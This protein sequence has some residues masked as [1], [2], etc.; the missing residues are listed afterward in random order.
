[1]KKYNNRAIILASGAGARSGLKIPK[2][3]A[4]INGRTVLERGI[5]AFEN[6]DGIDEI[7]LV[8][9]PQ[10][11]EKCKKIVSKNK[12]KKVIKIIPGGKTRQQSAYAGIS[13]VENPRA[14]ILIHDA[15]RPFVTA[16][17]IT[18]CINAL[19][20]YKAAGTAVPSADTIIKINKNNTVESV[21]ERGSLMRC[22]TPQA[23]KLEIIKKAHE[24]ALK[25][26]LA[27][28]TD[29]CGLVLRFKLAPVY[30]VPGDDSNIKITYPADILT[31]Q[32]ICRARDKQ[33]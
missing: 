17:I 29:D 16:R 24:L 8:S 27:S 30:V 23:F 14:N 22:Q 3:F 33:K 21:L 6:H 19:K 20:K 18:D 15:A 13:E 9:A 25:N 5:D 4:L 32:N 11:L 10:Y 28:V 31:A 2:Q 26:N 7:I 12:Y 1:M